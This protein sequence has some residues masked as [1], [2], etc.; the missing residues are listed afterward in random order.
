M[1]VWFKPE[2]FKAKNQRIFSW[3]PSDEDRNEIRL[4]IS[5]KQES[6][7]RRQLDATII[8]ESGF[9]GGTYKTYI[10]NTELNAG[11]WYHAVM[12]WDGVNLSLTLDGKSEPVEKAVDGSVTLRNVP[13]NRFIGAGRNVSQSSFDG[14]IDDIRIYNRALSE[15]EVAE[16]YDLEKP[17]DVAPPPPSEYKIIEGSFTWH[18]AKADA[19]ARGGHLATI[20]GQGEQSKINE[21]IK[22]SDKQYWL[23]ATDEESEKDWKWITGE[24][25]IYTNWDHGSDFD[26]TDEEDYMFIRSFK[27]LWG[28]A[29]KGVKSGYVLEIPKVDLEMGLVAYYPFNG[30]ANDESENNRDGIDF[31]ENYLTEDRNGVSNSAL[32]FDGSDPLEFNNPA[33]GYNDVTLSIWV[34][35][36]KPN[37]GTDVLFESPLLLLHADQNNHYWLYIQKDRIGGSD[38]KQSKR[39]ISNSSFGGN[40]WNH[41]IM[42]YKEDNS[43]KFYF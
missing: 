3:G 39:Y 35:L 22:N 19:E 31:K 32:F 1:A 21:I 11:T 12:T 18:E 33:S 28:D 5:D 23:G 9:G 38:T 6:S 37:S 17:D 25:F 14:Q 26:N 29:D 42:T 36:S 24:S 43:A 16:L 30:N 15:A 2:T 34:K 4:Q 8:D 40:D 13:R 10:G 20:T 27:N 7:Q 41:I